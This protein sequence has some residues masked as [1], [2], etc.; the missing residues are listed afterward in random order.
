MQEQK[1]G[2]LKKEKDFFIG[3]IVSDGL[4][5]D[6]IKKGQIE[7][8]SA[9]GDFICATLHTLDPREHHDYTLS[10]ATMGIGY[11]I[12]EKDNVVK[13]FFLTDGGT[14]NDLPK[15]LKEYNHFDDNRVL[16]KKLDDGNMYIFNRNYNSSDAIKQQYDV[17]NIVVAVMNEKMKN[18]I[19]CCKKD[20]EN[21]KNV[22]KNV[23]SAVSKQNNI[24]DYSNN[25]MDSSFSNDNYENQERVSWCEAVKNKKDAS[26][27]IV[28]YTHNNKINICMNEMNYLAEDQIDGKLKLDRIF[29]YK[30]YLTNPLKSKDKLLQQNRNILNISRENF[31]NQTIRVIDDDDTY[32]MLSLEDF[33]KQYCQGNIGC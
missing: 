25:Q 20:L 12:S 8:K 5:K 32:Q 26:D 10:F 15:I 29:V 6:L 30:N 18:R 27:H 28:Y 3:H 23:G 2:I 24:F 17:N 31:A 4:K 9:S 33:E 16:Y 14:N 1:S 21:K 19:S 11:E 7:C 13:N 22:K